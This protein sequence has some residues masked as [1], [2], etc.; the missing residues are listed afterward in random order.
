MAVNLNKHQEALMFCNN[1]G[2]QND[3]GVRFCTVCGNDLMAA[4]NQQQ[5]PQGNTYQNPQGGFDPAFQNNYQN[6]QGNFDPAFQNNY[7]NP[8]GNF[9]PAFY[10]QQFGMPTNGTSTPGKGLGI[11]SMILGIVVLVL[12]CV[13]YIS[14]PCA[15]TGLV[16]G[17]ISMKK[18]KA[19]GASHGMATAGIICS[20]IGLGLLVI[21]FLLAIIGFAGMA[22][23]GMFY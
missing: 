6:P 14:L 16:L 5:N 12:L 21:F 4:Q 3:D 19:V 9:D 18:A 23:M 7:Q 22:S 10:N 13:Y 8:Q 2:K 11:A 20:A 17:I 1:C 15:I